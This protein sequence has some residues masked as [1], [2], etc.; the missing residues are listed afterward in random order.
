[1]TSTGSTTRWFYVQYPARLSR[2]A[3]ER[4]SFVHHDLPWVAAA[5]PELKEAARQK[6]SDL[7]VNKQSDFQTVAH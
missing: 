2:V 1:M 7:R 6:R 4:R 5:L 3:R